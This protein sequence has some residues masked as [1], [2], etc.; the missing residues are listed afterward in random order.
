MRP[1]MI[2]IPLVSTA[3]ADPQRSTTGY[4]KRLNMILARRRAGLFGA[5]MFS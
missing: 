2:E 5:K 1:L 3:V 4:N